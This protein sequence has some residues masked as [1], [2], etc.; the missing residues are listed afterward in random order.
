MRLFSIPDLISGRISYI[1]LTVPF[2]VRFNAVHSDGECWPD[3]V[4]EDRGD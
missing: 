4:P 1:Q 3:Y 2:P